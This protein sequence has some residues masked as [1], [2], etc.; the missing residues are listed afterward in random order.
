MRTFVLSITLA[1]AAAHADIR[2]ITYEFPENPGVSLLFGYF[3]SDHPVEGMIVET[4]VFLEFDPDPGID[5]AH[6]FSGFSVPV[7]ALPGGETELVIL[8]ADI[9]WS[10]DDVQRFTLVTSLH[11]GEIRPGRF[12]WEIR[13]DDDMAP[14][15]GTILP[16]SRIEFDVVPAPASLAALGAGLLAVRRRR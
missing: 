4:R 3:G 16:G 6:F 12:G 9:G 1:A 8:G 14:L 7:I 11:N 10:G 2:T 15:R 5:A 13:S